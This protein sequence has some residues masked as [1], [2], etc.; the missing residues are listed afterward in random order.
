MESEQQAAS[1][2]MEYK[3]NFGLVTHLILT[4]KGKA[5]KHWDTN[6]VSTC[7]FWEVWVVKHNYH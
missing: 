2:C 7:F 6:F 4:E 1:A 3:Y 5:L